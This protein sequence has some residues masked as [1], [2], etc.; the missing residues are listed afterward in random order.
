MSKRAFGIV[1]AAPQYFHVEGL[2]DYRPIGAFSFLGRY[3][4]VDFPISNMSNSGIDSIQVYIGGKPRSITEH[5][6]GGRYFNINSKKGRLD[7]LFSRE[8]ARTNNTNPY[9][10]DIEA[11]I[12]NLGPIERAPQPYVIIVP[13]YMVYRQDYEALLNQHIE[14]GADIT[15]LYHRVDDAKEHFL[16]CNYLNLNRQKG[17][18]SIERNLGNTKDKNIFMDTYVMKK[19]LFIELIQEARKESSMFR[20][21]QIISQKASE[22]DIRGVAHKGYFASLTDLKSYFDASLELLDVK[23]AADLFDDK[24]TFYTRTTD[25]CPTQYFEGAKVRNSMISN[26][27]MIEGTVENSIIGRGVTIHKGAVVRNCVVQAYSEIGENVHLENLVVDKWA[28]I[29]H[30]QEIVAEADNP[31]YI[32]KSDVI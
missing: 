5:L 17:V 20:L 25:S 12:E 3:R 18:L 24:W 1:T 16:N 32:R 31:G 19:E 7:L 30:A 21:S 11:F 9:D 29:G 8:G 28:K 2:H 15:L 23:K 4:V 13:S 22:L 26:G 14:S 10:T 27:S 6:S